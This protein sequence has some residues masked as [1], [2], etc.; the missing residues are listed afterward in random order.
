MKGKVNYTALVLLLLAIV[1][2]GWLFMG[3]QQKATASSS[4]IPNVTAPRRRRG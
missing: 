2:L 4:D 1:G 3:Q